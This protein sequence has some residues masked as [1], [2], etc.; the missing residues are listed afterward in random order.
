[1]FAECQTICM[2]DETPSFVGPH[3]DLIVYKGYQWCLNSPLA[4]KELKQ[5][6]DMP[7]SKVP[8]IFMPCHVLL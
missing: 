5:S 4:D 6:R 7:S 2:S 3:F 1:M 8:D